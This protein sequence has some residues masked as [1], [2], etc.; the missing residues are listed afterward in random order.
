MTLKGQLVLSL[1]EDDIYK[2]QRLC[3]IKTMNGKKE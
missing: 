1:F 2:L 3:S